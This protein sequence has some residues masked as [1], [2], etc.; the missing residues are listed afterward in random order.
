[1][2]QANIEE[3]YKEMSTAQKSAL[4]IIALG[5]RWAT[6]ILRML[7]PEEVRK[8]SYW[9]NKMDHVPQ[10]ITEKVIKDF[11]ERLVKKT[12]LSSTGG[13]DYLLDVLSGMMGESRA[14]ELVD[15]LAEGESS[16]VFRILKQVEPA[17]LAT[18]LKQEQPQ[19]V[20]LMLSH[21]DPSR[22]AQIITAMPEDKQY[23]VLLRIAKLEETD[24]EIISAMERTLTKSLGPMATGKQSK[25]VGGTKLVAEILNNVGKETENALMEQ[26]GETDFDL[27][28]EIKDLMFVFADVILLDDKSIQ[29]VV[30]DVDGGDL[31]LAL[32][33]ANDAVKEKI[34]RNISKRQVDT[35]ND[36]L[37]FM[38]PVKAST[39]NDAQQKIVNI[40]R[41]LDAEGKILIQGKG[42]ADD[43]IA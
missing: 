34:F 38:G 8:I 43:I 41:K 32:K 19:T 27:A 10:E 35:I 4:L 30:K 37:S 24:Q 5:Q 42:G 3:T 23:E 36:E 25:K 18:F 12:S 21:L 31:V 29:S 40:I 15:D 9:I 28:T 13:R 2:A 6:E 20:A 7:K 17:K 16:E 39:V 14:Q 1:M 11:Y 33:G 22:S 26:I